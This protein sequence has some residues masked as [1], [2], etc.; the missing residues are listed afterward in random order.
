MNYR[1]IVLCGIVAITLMGTSFAAN[2]VENSV[3]IAVV[4]D[5]LTPKEIKLSELPQAVK[6]SLKANKSVAERAFLLYKD[7]QAIYEIEATKDGEKIILR[8]DA[9]GKEIVG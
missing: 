9:S 1:K 8:Y 2:H 4:N 7:E 5:D 3:A 6:N